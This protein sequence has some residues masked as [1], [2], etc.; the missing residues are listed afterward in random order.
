[1]SDLLLERVRALLAEQDLLSPEALL[2]VAVSGGPD[3][4]CLLHLLTPLRADGGPRLHV[5][6]FDH[7]ARGAQATAE[8]AAVAELGT[9]WGLAVTVEHRDVPALARASGISFMAAARQARYAFLANLAN[10]IEAHA[11]AVAHQADDQAET[12]LLHL[13]RG[14]GLAGLRGMRPVVPWHEW[15]ADQGSGVRGQGSGVRGQGSGV[16]GQG[17]GVRGQGSLPWCFGPNSAA[18][19][20]PGLLLSNDLEFPTL[21]LIAATVEAHSNSRFV[22]DRPPSGRVQSRC[23]A[24]PDV[25]VRGPRR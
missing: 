6:H 24:R 9:A 16:R 5:A 11:V 12:V 1:M 22:S 21:S 2:L 8:A 4:L 17:S 14:A 25:A 13:L 20:I 3:S 18:C 15:A 7:G 10:R 23:E 19:R